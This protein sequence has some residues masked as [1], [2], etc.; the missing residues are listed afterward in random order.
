MIA[1]GPVSLRLPSGCHT[2]PG[3]S[4]AL[5]LVPEWPTAGV[6]D[7]QGVAQRRERRPNTVVCCADGLCMAD[8]DRRRVSRHIPTNRIEITWT[9]TRRARWLKR[10]RPVT[11]TILDLSGNGML[12]DLPSELNANI[13]DIVALSSD[14]TDAV[15]RVV[16]TVRDEEWA[17]QW[18]G[19][20]IT[21]MS[22]EFAAKL[23]V[24]V[25]ALGDDHAQ[26]AESWLRQSAP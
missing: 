12:M 15:A 26:L 8:L 13:G 22:S 18:V 20:E 1:C 3:D 10:K 23:N 2:V 16:H 9:P 6:N 24:L 19:V 25:T 14:G 11:A 17:Q 21:E 4:N 5:S 7:A